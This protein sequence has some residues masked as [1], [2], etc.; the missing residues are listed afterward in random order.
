MREII[1]YSTNFCPY[2]VQVKR[3]LT[4]QGL[5][6]S[7]INLENDPDLRLKLS[8]ANGGWRTVPMVTIGDEF[9]GGYME[10][11]A[12]HKKGELIKKAEQ[13]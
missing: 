8:A 1:V 2:C 7:D 5:K 12:L 9:I 3:L 10:V 13:D 11:L 4:Q 6:F